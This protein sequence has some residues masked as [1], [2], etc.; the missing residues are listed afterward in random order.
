M[1]ARSPDET[2]ML[3]LVPLNADGPDD[4][5][6]D[7]PSAT[8]FFAIPAPR[9]ERS[10]PS[11]SAPAP[12]PAPPPPSP[13]GPPPMG[14]IQGPTP[15]YRAPAPAA[16]PAPMG[17]IQGP[18]ASGPA[19]TPFQASQPPP[20]APQKEK[21]VSS[22]R[23]YALVLAVFMLG[24]TAVV[25]AVWFG[26]MRTKTDPEP[27]ST[28]PAVAQAPDV[29]DKPP[30]DTGEEPEPEPK[31]RRPTN[32]RPS[33][34]TPAAPAAPATNPGTLTVKMTDQTF[35]TTIEVTCPSGMRQRAPITTGGSASI[36]NV[37]NESCVLHF[38]GGAPARFS[39][40]SGGQSISCQIIGSTAVCK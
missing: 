2:G 1:G 8:A 19:G 3:E 11:P 27:S 10:S 14:G 22:F 32:P 31:P 21:R 30:K 34:P 4:G 9:A 40:V 13:A 39:P 35:L 5:P 15:G 16:P 28:T 38:K 7:D 12:T 6:G 17:G 33:N 24:C 23:V 29:K 18:T 20:G 36:A 26:Q 25:L 37:P